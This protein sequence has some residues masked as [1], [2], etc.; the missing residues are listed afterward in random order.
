MKPQPQLVSPRSANRA[1]A[2]LKAGPVTARARLQISTAGIVAVGG[3]VG[4]ILLS[5]AVLVQV[6]T[7]IPR[8]RPATALL[9]RKLR[10]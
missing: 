5:T 9:S 1:V 6:A 3:L 4:S 7:A 2:I 8:A 10:R